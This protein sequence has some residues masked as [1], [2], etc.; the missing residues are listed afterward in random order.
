MIELKELIDK[1]NDLSHT[2]IDKEEELVFFIN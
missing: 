1:K 2:L